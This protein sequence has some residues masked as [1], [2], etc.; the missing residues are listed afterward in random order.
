M[1]LRVIGAGLGRTGTMS[2]KLA[3]EQIGFGRCYHMAEVMMDVM[4]CGTTMSPSCG[5]F[6][7]LTTI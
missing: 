5:L 1:A 2:M 7:R 3:L 4:R 6:K